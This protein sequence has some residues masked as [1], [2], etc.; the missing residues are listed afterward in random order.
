MICVHEWRLKERG[1]VYFSM[2][3]HVCWPD[4]FYCV[5][6]LATRTKGHS[7]VDGNFV[8]VDVISS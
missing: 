4:I 6:C 3:S 2:L 1:G 7:G 5:S 8:E